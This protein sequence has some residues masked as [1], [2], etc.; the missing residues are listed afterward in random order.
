M[1]G[2]S[3]DGGLE[4]NPSSEKLA[5]TGREELFLTWSQVVCIALRTS[6]FLVISPYL[7]SCNTVVEP[8][9]LPLFLLFP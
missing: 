3:N 2:G 8:L 7:C 6:A 1:G 4:N 9:P 5:D